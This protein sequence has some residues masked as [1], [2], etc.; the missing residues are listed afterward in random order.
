ME[1]KERK[2]SIGFATRPETLKW[3]DMKAQHYKKSRSEIIDACIKLVQDYWS[4]LVPTSTFDKL[5][6]A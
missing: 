4:E 3:L 2:I 6:R 5:L 1:E